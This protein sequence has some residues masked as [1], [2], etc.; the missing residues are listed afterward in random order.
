MTLVP[1]T[2][3]QV[4]EDQ[5]RLQ[6]EHEREVAKNSPDPKAIIKAPAER[7]STPG[8]SGRLDKH[9]SLL[10][11]N[12]EVRKLLLSKQV[13]YVLYCKEVILLSHEAS[14]TYLL[15]SLLCCRDL[16]TFSQTR[17]QAGFHHS[18]GSSTRSTS[19]LEHPCLTDRPTRWV[20]RR[21]KRSNG[22]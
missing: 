15:K 4:H 16:R 10:A 6:Q 12:R 20:L 11:K 14:M 18:E 7:T 17:S 21:L 19:F 2:P 13:V 5:L 1:L 8:T 3:Q 22:K 9:P